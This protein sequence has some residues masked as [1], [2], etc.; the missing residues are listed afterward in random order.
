VC[1]LQLGDQPTAEE[2]FKQALEA[3][4]PSADASY[5]LGQLC[6]GRRDSGG[7]AFYYETAAQ[8]GHG[9]AAERLA[10]LQP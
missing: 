5:L 1:A 8:L 6:E 7:A 4:D 9:S 10:A 3:D 2:W